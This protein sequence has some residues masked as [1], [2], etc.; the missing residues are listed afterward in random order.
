M[1]P[2]VFSG[3]ILDAVFSFLANVKDAG[4]RS[5]VLESTH[6]WCVQFYVEWHTESPLLARLQAGSMAVDFQRSKVLWTY[7]NVVSFL[8]RAFATDEF[9]E[10]TADY[11]NDF[12]PGKDSIVTEETYS[13]V[14][15]AKVLRCG[16]V[17]FDRRMKPLS[18]NGPLQEPCEKNPQLFSL[19]P[20]PDQHT[21]V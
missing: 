8:L 4:S 18:I 14:L 3:T 15:W 17:F 19:S 7:R 11:S 13:R 21:A 12:S 2:A 5:G 9:I 1:L 20:W 10:F 16:T 6:V